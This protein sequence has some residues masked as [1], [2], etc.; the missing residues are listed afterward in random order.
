[1]TKSSATFDPSP[2]KPNPLHEYYSTGFSLPKCFDKYVKK[3]FFNVLPAT[4]ANS[5]QKRL[6][7]FSIHLMTI[8]SFAP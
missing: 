4:H 7:P 3:R 1:M 5:V 2:E 6:R 8:I